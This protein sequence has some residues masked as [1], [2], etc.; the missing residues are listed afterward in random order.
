MNHSII[1]RLT[2]T[3]L[4]QLGTFDDNLYTLHI[5]L[6]LEMLPS[7]P[8]LLIDIATEVSQKLESDQYDYLLC[9]QDSLP[10]ALLVSHKTSIPLVYENRAGA[11]PASRLI[12][13]YDVGHPTCV[14]SLT[15]QNADRLLDDA[16]KVG[17]DVVDR[18]AV[19]GTKK[20]AFAKMTLFD[21]DKIYSD[22]L[23][24]LSHPNSIAP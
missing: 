23:D 6:Q 14:V 7:Y 19:F 5:R 21:L 4:L 20:S 15:D 16:Q 8:S 2:S 1:R 9:P 12:G 17:L 22:L 13:S 10:V 18:I 24:E 11:S 3:G